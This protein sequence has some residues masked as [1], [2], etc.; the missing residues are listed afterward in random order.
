VDIGIAALLIALTAA[1]YNGFASHAFVNFDDRSYVTEN[2][3][4]S[5]GLSWRAIEW[6]F[7]TGYAGN[8][9]PVTWLSHLIDVELF[10][11]QP[12]GHHLTSIVLHAA[13]GILLFIALRRL[14]GARWPSAFV[15]AVFAVHPLHVESVAW[16]AERKDVLSTFFLLL[17]LICYQRYVAA[18]GLSRM[19]AVTIFFGAGLMAKPMLVT[20]PVLL[21]LLDVWPLGRLQWSVYTHE[22][23]LAWLRLIREKAVL[24]LLALA[25]GVI[26]ILA[27][28]GGGALSTFER[29]PLSRRMA[30][31]VVSYGLYLCAAFWPSRLAVFYPYPAQVPVWSLIIASVLLL[32]FSVIAIVFARRYPYVR[33]GWLWFLVTLLPVIGLVQVGGQAMADRYMYIP[34]IGLLVIV[35]WGIPDLIGRRPAFLAVGGGLAIVACSL[36][37]ESQFASWKNSLTLWRHAVAVGADNARAHNLLGRSLDEDGRPDEA[38]VEYREAV[39]LDPDDVEARN[40]LGLAFAH[41]GRF[42]DAIEQYR[43]A[44]QIREN[45]SEAANNLGSV[46]AATGKMEEAERVLKRAVALQPDSAEAHNNLGNV[47]MSEEQ[48]KN[49]I[50]EYESALSINPEFADAQNGLGAALV[51]GGRQEEAIPHLREA[52]RLS[53]GLAQAHRNLATALSL[54]EHLEEA[55]SELLAALSIEPDHAEWHAIAADWLLR[56]G[57]RDAAIQHLQMALSI[58]PANA[59]AQ[60]LLGSL[61]QVQ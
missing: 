36:V 25:S 32:S 44:L 20:V 13:N 42:D 9:H 28:R 60:R 57:R 50:A 21:L 1:V 55:A 48:E 33:A 56:L 4:V 38:I 54:G 15:A 43:A 12:W 5:S 7:S 41:Q 61:G 14:T 30:N 39:R 58:D 19:L 34:M 45:F 22:D 17:T 23:R 11:L 26:T 46:L 18:P 37:A 27:Q 29:L 53:P 3:Q 35:A 31:A 40:N 6:A 24:F 47:L 16:V 51:Q 2:P 59:S 8:W 49:A 10:G 52:I